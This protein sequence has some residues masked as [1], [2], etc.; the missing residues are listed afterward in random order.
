MASGFGNINADSVLG[1][2][3]SLWPLHETS[4]EY[5]SQL[6]PA[7]GHQIPESLPRNAAAEARVDLPPPKVSQATVGYPLQ[8]KLPA[9]RRV[10]MATQ[11]LSVPGNA[12]LIGL[13]VVQGSHQCG[14]CVWILPDQ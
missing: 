3:L 12:A 11:E 2:V 4:R 7:L 9:A 5:C 10:S 8:Q 1:P 14:A 6:P 13:S